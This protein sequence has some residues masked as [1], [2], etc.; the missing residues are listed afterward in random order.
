MRHHSQLAEGKP[1]PKSAAFAMLTCLTT[2]NE[3]FEQL[4][5]GSMVDQRPMIDDL[6]GQPALLRTIQQGLAND[7]GSG[8][9]MMKS[10]IREPPEITSGV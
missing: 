10:V 2:L 3:W 1:Q 9:G 7:G 6:A 8:A 5:T 4:L